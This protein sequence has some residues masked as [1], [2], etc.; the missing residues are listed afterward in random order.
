MR[1]LWMLLCIGG[2]V[3]AKAP[4]HAPPSEAAAATETIEPPT[5]ARLEDLLRA[6]PRLV[7]VMDQ[8]STTRLQIVLGVPAT[9]DGWQRREG[10][11]DGAEYFY[12]ASA[13][14]LCIAVAAL[15]T[16]SELREGGT[17]NLDVNTVLASSAKRPIGST[18]VVTLVDRSLVVSDNDASNELFD[19]VGFDGIHERMWRLGLGSFRMHH[20][21]G[22]SQTDDARKSPRMALRGAM[23]LP[24]RTGR[25]VLDENDD[26][27]LSVGEGYFVSGRLVS[28]PMSFARKNRVALRDLQDLLIAVV[29]PELQSGSVPKL[30]PK[31]H[32]VLLDALSALPSDRGSA[33]VSD[34]EQK[35]LFD[36]AAR[37]VPRADLAV[38]SKAGRA[39]GFVVDNAYVADKRTGRSFFLAVAVYTNDNGRLNDDVYEYWDRAFPIL[40]D[41]GE[42]I[43]RAV[44]VDPP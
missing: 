4:R 43:A 7:S 37:V 1:T 14:K 30:G 35:P 21:L 28:E 24:P 32:A 23:T 11:R 40:G 10:F 41:I 29:R 33:V 8:A 13:I 26:R 2:C 44:F 36:G 34:A 19:L 5:V 42:T 20:R 16:L 15:E 22:T 3:D 9:R 17:R 25:L 39:F 27:G 6:N 31:E 38:A 12:P 18:S